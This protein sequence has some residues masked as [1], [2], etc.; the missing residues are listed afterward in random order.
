[1]SPFHQ[2][3]CSHAVALVGLGDVVIL[4]IGRSR[5]AAFPIGVMYD[6]HEA[7]ESQTAVTAKELH[8][9]VQ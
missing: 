7:E 6:N 1:M 3:Q 2:V 9:A 8:C 4:G 5:L